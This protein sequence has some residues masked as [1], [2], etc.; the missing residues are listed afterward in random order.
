MADFI[1]IIDK[2]ALYEAAD[3][4]NI[5]AVVGGINT[6]YFAPSANFSLKFA[7]GE[8]EKFFNIC[9]DPDQIQTVGLAEDFDGSKLSIRDGDIES[10][11]TLG[12]TSLKIERVF[13]TK[14]TVAPK[15][16][17][18]FS[19]GVQFFYQP[20]LTQ[21]AIAEGCVRPDNVVG[22]YA[23]YCDKQGHYKDKNGNTLA[24]YGCGKIGHLYAPYWTD[25]AG[26]KI[27]GTQEIQGNTLA[28]VLPPQEWIDAAILPIT[29]DPDIGYS[30]IGA[31]KGANAAYTYACGPFSAGSSGT[32]DTVSAYV[33]I[34]SNGTD[35]RLGYYDAKT[36]PLADN[37][38]GQSNLQTLDTYDYNG[39]NGALQV[40]LTGGVRTI[41]SG[42]DYF[43]A[44]L[45]ASGTMSVY[46]DTISANRYYGSSSGDDFVDPFTYTSSSSRQYSVWVDYTE[47]S[48]DLPNKLIVPLADNTVSFLGK[49]INSGAVNTIAGSAVINNSG[50][51]G[52]NGVVDS[53]AEIDAIDILG[54]IGKSGFVE[55]S[56][57]SAIIN[58]F[59]HDGKAGFIDL[60]LQVVVKLLG[61]EAVIIFTGVL[62]SQLMDN[63]FSSSGSIGNNGNLTLQVE[64]IISALTGFKGISGIADI[65]VFTGTQILA[66]L[67]I[68]GDIDILLSDLDVRMVEVSVSGRIFQIL[69]ST[70]TGQISILQPKTGQINITT[71]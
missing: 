27:K 6:E 11:F 5:K 65:N 22:S 8:E 61:L 36:G 31:S 47:D 48:G 35:I 1:K 21:E 13:Y 17:L 9:D 66:K 59:G 16:K 32:A 30:T 37:L 18:A 53:L 3:T 68:K 71:Q 33:D 4:E 49:K 62:N 38:I 67:G 51:D 60:D 28:F 55:S 57:G 63:I 52:K 69:I 15:Y 7:S 64:N 26:V 29:L 2:P 58:N 23:V 25:A 12:D 42:D 50:Q 43:T 34:T 19:P 24:N 39:T 41:V 56:A 20:E 54:Q 44:F 45:R 10:T 46:Y 14:P 70:K 40:S